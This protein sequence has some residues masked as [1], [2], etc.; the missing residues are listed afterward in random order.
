MRIIC[1]IIFLWILSKLSLVL[2]LWE[3][4]VF[5]EGLAWQMSPDMGK[6]LPRPNSFSSPVVDT[7]I[8]CRYN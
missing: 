1:G 7:A 5:W 6:C 3:G 4:A 8:L 2:I